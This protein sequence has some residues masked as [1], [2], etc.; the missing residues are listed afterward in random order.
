LAGASAG[1]SVSLDGL[2]CRYPARARWLADHQAEPPGGPRRLALEVACDTAMGPNART[3]E[4]P[5]LTLLD[6]AGRPY[7][8]ETRTRFPER[9]AAA[10]KTAPPRDDRSPGLSA[11]IAAPPPGTTFSVRA[12]FALPVVL[13][14]GPWQLQLTGPGRV[15][16]LPLELP[17][18]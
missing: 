13:P 9:A 8:E 12:L 16:Q 7:P 5:A 2:T 14:A 4:L 11:R 6:A 10:S 18:E 3:A 1:N 17:S 15:I